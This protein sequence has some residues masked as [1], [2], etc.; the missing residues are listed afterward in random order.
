MPTPIQASAASIREPAPLT[1]ISA[2]IVPASVPFDAGLAW[3]GVD[4]SE[5][6]ARQHLQLSRSARL[7]GDIQIG[8]GSLEGY[9]TA[10]ADHDEA[11]AR[12]ATI[13]SDVHSGIARGGIQIH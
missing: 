10:I 8:D 1:R 13:R 2:L 5:R 4:E 6:T 12:A 9:R 11:V 7:I 3:S